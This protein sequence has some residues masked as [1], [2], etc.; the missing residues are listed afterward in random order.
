MSSTIRRSCL[1]PKTPRLSSASK[2]SNR[3]LGLQL[4]YG[5]GRR[6]KPIKQYSGPMSPF[7][8]MEAGT[9]LKM[10]AD[11]VDEHRGDTVHEDV[12]RTWTGPGCHDAMLT[13]W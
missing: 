4:D 6:R 2:G 9:A 13:S 8:H 5:K 12:L 1:A 3:L 11:R 10:L 7:A